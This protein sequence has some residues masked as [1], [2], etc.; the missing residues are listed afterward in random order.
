MS[1]VNSSVPIGFRQIPGFPRYAISED[2]TILSIAQGGWVTSRP[3]CKARQLQP[4]TGKRGYKQVLLASGQGKPRL[5]CVHT[6]VLMAFV[7]PRPEG[8]ECR[9]LDGT[10]NNNNLSNLRWGTHA[11][12]SRDMILHGTSN[13]GERN[14]SAK[15]TTSDVL[16]IRRQVAD[17]KRQISIAREFCVSPSLVCAIMR[18]RAWNH[19][20]E[21]A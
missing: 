15:L 13:Q 12:N 10:R 9:H 16:A 19:L 3:W 7:G 21:E 11:E 17:G 2:G 18:G 6:L 4:H 20:A 1:D 14:P 8:A 5:M